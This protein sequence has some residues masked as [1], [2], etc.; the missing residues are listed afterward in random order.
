MISL[1]LS[2]RVFSAAA[3]GSALTAASI[4]T[5][6]SL[7]FFSAS[8]WASWASSMAGDTSALLGVDD[9]VDVRGG[10][11]LDSR[12]RLDWIGAGELRGHEFRTVLNLDF[13][14]FFDVQDGVGVIGLE[15]QAFH[16]IA[17]ESGLDDVTTLE[18]GGLGA[19][20]GQERSLT[21]GSILAQVDDW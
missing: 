19:Q 1:L 12:G 2:K 21:G 18:L 14:F 8:I 17:L 20:V 4:C 13:H 10:H 15:I 5:S 11:R 3:S 9:L 7:A 6:E 16:V